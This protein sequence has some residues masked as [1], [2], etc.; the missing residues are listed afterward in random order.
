MKRVKKKVA[1]IVDKRQAEI[2]TVAAHLRSL[3]AAG[4]S[5]E[6]HE[7]LLDALELGPRSLDELMDLVKTR[8]HAMDGPPA[9]GFELP[10]GHGFTLRVTYS[11]FRFHVQEASTENAVR[12][13]YNQAW[14]LLETS[15]LNHKGSMPCLFWRKKP[16]IHESFG[17]TTLRMRLAIP[18]VDLASFANP[19]G[20]EEPML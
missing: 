1:P 2:V 8:F 5:Q 18:G 16:E 11:T 7:D 13:L 20:G 10:D 14:K 9:Y 3:M 6:E 19:E 4:L 12:K 15:A 17:R